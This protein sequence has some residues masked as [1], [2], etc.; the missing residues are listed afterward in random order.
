M[1]FTSYIHQAYPYGHDR[2]KKELL[3]VCCLALASFLFSYLFEPFAMNEAEH[4]IK[5]IYI[6]LLHSTIPIP[7]AL[8]YLYLLNNTVKDPSNWTIGKEFLHLAIL[9]F[10]IGL[11][12]FLIRDLIYTNPDNWSLSYF[13]EEIRNTFLVGTLLLLII[14]PLNLERLLH[15]HLAPLKQVPHPPTNSNKNQTVYLTTPIEAEHF[16]LHLESFLFAKVE[17]NYLEIFFLQ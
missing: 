7:I 13:Y 11:C 15:K 3:L 17:G 16:T 10:L 2:F 9:L 8:G 5:S 6:L 12:D 4:K 14:L 1:K